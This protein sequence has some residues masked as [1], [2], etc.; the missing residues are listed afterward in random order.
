MTYEH[1][2]VIIKAQLNEPKNLRMRGFADTEQRGY[3]AGNDDKIG[4]SGQ[5]EILTQIEVWITQEYCMYFKFSKLKSWV[6]RSVV[7]R[8][9]FHQRFLW[10]YMKHHQIAGRKSVVHVIGRGICRMCTRLLCPVFSSHW[11]VRRKT[12]G[13][14]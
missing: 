4:K 7:R 14:C 8:R 5:R 11:F 10:R 1:L 9:R 2:F 3:R 13:V 6:K 12:K